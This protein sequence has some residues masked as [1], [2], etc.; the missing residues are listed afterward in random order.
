MKS[1]D[2]LST[3]QDEMHAARYSFPGAARTFMGSRRELDTLAGALQD[4]QAEL[5]VARG[6]LHERV[7]ALDTALFIRTAELDVVR[8]GRRMHAAAT[9]ESTSYTGAARYLLQ[10]IDA[11]LKVEM[12]PTTRL[13]DDAWGMFD[14]ANTELAGAHELKTLRAELDAKADLRQPVGR[15]RRAEHEEEPNTL[16]KSTS[17]PERLAAMTKGL[18]LAEGRAADIDEALLEIAAL[19]KELCTA[20]R[21]LLALAA[22]DAAGVGCDLDRYLAVPS[23]TCVVDFNM[24]TTSSSPAS[25]SMT[26]ADRS[27]SPSGISP[28]TLCSVQKFQCYLRISHASLFMRIPYYLS[29][30]HAFSLDVPGHHIHLAPALNGT[31]EFGLRMTRVRVRG[32]RPH[33]GSRLPRHLT[34]TKFASQRHSV[35]IPCVTEWTCTCWALK[36]MS[37]LPARAHRRPDRAQDIRGMLVHPPAFCDEMGKSYTHRVARVLT[38]GH[39]EEQTLSRKMCPSIITG[40]NPLTAA[41]LAHK[42]EIVDRDV[43]IIEVNVGELA[44]CSVDEAKLIP[45]MATARSP[46]PDSRAR[47]S[48]AGVR[49]CVL[50]AST[51]RSQFTGPYWFEPSLTS[52]GSSLIAVKIG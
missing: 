1:I 38:P 48:R 24:Q 49:V 35:M 4:A 36:R 15:S 43:L 44:W 22:D 31:P 13:L 50:L 19:A 45:M 28:T 26:N 21:S 37:P 18:R 10:S 5:D 27:P 29:Q 32:P 9:G 40:D 7:H 12:G 30:G 20:P 42:A 51:P 47:A 3:A 25:D 46:T 6:E 39:R 11:A 33:N 52:S 14:T 16:H 2:E 34:I 23:S 8:L 41:Q 17:A